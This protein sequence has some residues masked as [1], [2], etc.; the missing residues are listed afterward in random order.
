MTRSQ[1]AS[2]VFFVSCRYSYNTDNYVFNYITAN[3]TSPMLSELAAGTVEYVVTDGVIEQATLLNNTLQ[4]PVTGSAL[5]MAI[6]A[7]DFSNGLVPPVMSIPVHTKLR[8]NSPIIQFR[9]S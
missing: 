5:V 9:C 7:N 2:S 1:P 8:E 3:S 4:F 6:N